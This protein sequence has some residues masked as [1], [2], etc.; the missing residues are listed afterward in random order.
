[1]RTVSSVGCWCPPLK[2]WKSNRK[3]HGEARRTHTDLVARGAGS[4]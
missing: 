3:L 2:L 4:Q 1:M